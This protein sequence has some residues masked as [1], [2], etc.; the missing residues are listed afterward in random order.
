M[1]YGNSLYLIFT[2]NSN[3][4]LSDH[5]AKMTT[6]FGPSADFLGPEP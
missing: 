6:F 3:L 4:V 5:Q 2:Y 1:S